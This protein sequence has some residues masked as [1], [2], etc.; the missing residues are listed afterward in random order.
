MKITIMEMQKK[1]LYL[2]KLV[3]QNLSIFQVHQKRS[4]K[5]ENKK[6]YSANILT[7]HIMLR[8]YAIIAIIEKAGQKRQN[9]VHIEIEPCIVVDYA[10]IVI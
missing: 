5:R 8:V 10:R 7:S 6:K 1:N 3:S 2:K 4:E 9:N